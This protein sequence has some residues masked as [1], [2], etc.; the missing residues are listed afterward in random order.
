MPRPPFNFN[1]LTSTDFEEFC[2][3]LLKS[4]NFVNLSWRKGTG[5]S[6]SP[7]D[8]GRDIEAQL[9]RS[10]VDGSHHVERW[11]IECKHYEKG[12][13]PEKLQS[14]IAWA[15]AERPDML[16]FCVSNFLSN[17]AK[18]YLEDFVRNNAP[19][20]RI[21]VW[22]RKDLEHLTAEKYDLRRRYRLT[23]ELAFVDL[24]NKYHLIYAMR[25]QLNSVSYFLELMDSLDAE[26]R[27]QAFSTSYMG[28]VQPRLRK[29][30]TGKETLRELQIDKDGYPEFRAKL[31]VDED[32]LSPM[33]I[34][35]LVT[36]ALAWLFK[37]A[38]RTTMEQTKEG[39]EWIVRKLEDDAES[40]STDEER[41]MFLK[42][43]DLPR[44]VLNELPARTERFYS[45][46][47]Y[48]CDELVRK[49]L[50]ETPVIGR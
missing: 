44:S 32:Q 15:N 8:Q 47:T 18:Q 5:L 3:D 36:F 31:L 30:I 45:L 13:P 39:N 29:P 48:I 25:P 40:A 35:G 22:E 17:P 27:D 19:T 9:P 46:Y 20:Y 41:A 1:S 6:T 23:T 7:S 10:E 4:L 11:F 24:L 37:L 26:K 21:K 14:G 33:Y 49:L 12:V 2:F 34:H 28:V 43:R 50:A 16:L 38:D 42:M